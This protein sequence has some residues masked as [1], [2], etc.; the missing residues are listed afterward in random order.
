[1]FYRIDDILVI[2]KNTIIIINIKGCG[3]I[4]VVNTIILYTVFFVYCFLI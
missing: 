1:M 4:L 2:I 3:K